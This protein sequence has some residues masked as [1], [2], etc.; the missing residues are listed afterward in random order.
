LVDVVPGHSL[1]SR[2]ALRDQA[3][4]ALSS[5]S[6]LLAR[7]GRLS[8]FSRVR[9][10]RG[11]QCKNRIADMARVPEVALTAVIKLAHICART[12]VRLGSSRSARPG[13]VI[14]GADWGVC[15]PWIRARSDEVLPPTRR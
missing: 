7:D 15:G 9:A 13:S 4:R 12:N 1:G 2:E 6:G 5:V 10:A 11:Q 8:S 14:Y 3:A